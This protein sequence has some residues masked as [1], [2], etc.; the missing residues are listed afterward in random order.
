MKTPPECPQPLR[1]YEADPTNGQNVA[2]GSVERYELEIRKI[3]DESL[4]RDRAVV[5]LGVFAT[6]RD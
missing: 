6:T 3:L 5:A 1:A 2:D 4:E